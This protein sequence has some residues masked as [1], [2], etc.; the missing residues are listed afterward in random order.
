MNDIANQELTLV[1]DA[2]WRPIGKKT[3]KDA[4][5][6]LCS[7]AVNAIDFEYE[8]NDNGEL[9]NSRMTP[10]PWS[11]WINLPI[12]QWNLRINTYNRS[13]RVPTVIIAK[14]FS[15]TIKKKISLS[16]K[17]VAERD[18]WTCQYSNQKLTKK[19]ASMDHILP[20]YRGGKDEWKNIVLCHKDINSKKGN[21]YNHEVGLQLLKNPSEPL[22]VPVW[23]LIKEAKHREWDYFLIKN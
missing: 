13:F 23:S 2:L 8:V 11:E 16:L 9:I 22:S 17:N 10:V 14:K 7:D 6:S 1:L 19:T 3:V 12:Y 5:T 15:K 4:I 18:N 21:R 20:K